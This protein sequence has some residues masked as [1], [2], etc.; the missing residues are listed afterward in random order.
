MEKEE[1]NTRDIEINREMI[2]EE[3]V[4]KLKL[5]GERTEKEIEATKDEMVSLEA[6]K[7]KMEGTLAQRTEAGAKEED[8]AKLA[9]LEKKIDRADAEEKGP[10]TSEINT[11]VQRTPSRKV[12]PV[13]SFG[14]E[15]PELLSEEESL[16]AIKMELAKTMNAEFGVGCTV[17]RSGNE[18]D[19]YS[20]GE[21]VGTCTYNLETRSFSSKVEGLDEEVPI[22]ATSNS[23]AISKVVGVL[24]ENAGSVAKVSDQPE[25]ITGDDAKEEHLKRM[26]EE[27]NK[28]AE[29]PEDQES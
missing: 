21:K 7:Q 15:T 18:F 22:E 25:L 24:K 20:K 2:N 4:R 26:I 5:E 11:V 28:L 10:E 23:E 27:A 6:N 1:E 12:E 19:M 9:D 14:A 3:L 17:D 16:N 8:A 13:T 29:N